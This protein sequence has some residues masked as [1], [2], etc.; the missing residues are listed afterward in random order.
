MASYSK[1]QTKAKPKPK[2]KPKPKKPS[3]KELISKWAMQG[4]TKFAPKKVYTH[5]ERSQKREASI[6]AKQTPQP[7]D[8]EEEEV[9]ER[10]ERTPHEL[11][12]ARMIHLAQQLQRTMR[13][14]KDEA[15]LLECEDPSEY[16]KVAE[17]L[18]LQLDELMVLEAVFM[19][20]LL[21]VPDDLN[22]LR[23]TLET[24]EESG[25]VDEDAIFALIKRAPLEFSLQ[26]TIK[27]HRPASDEKKILVATILLNVILPPLY[28]TPGTLL[29]L[30]FVDV[31]ITDALEGC[32]YA[33]SFIQSLEQLDE[34]RLIQAMLDKAT[35]IQGTELFPVVFELITWLSENAFIF[36]TDNGRN[37]ELQF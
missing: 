12:C 33:N 24:V 17:C 25:F 11:A 21:L 36:L 1:H 15:S 5:G 26:L 30:E 7:G 29:D 23:A 2:T 32:G 16:S 6:K 14:Q 8:E 13:E 18:K 35:A 9:E 20:E 28:P 34:D 4:G 27:D 31:M 3:H 19:D 37:D 10:A 22:E